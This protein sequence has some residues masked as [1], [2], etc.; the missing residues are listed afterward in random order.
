[1]ISV[2]GELAVISHKHARGFVK[3]EE[4]QFSKVKYVYLH[5]LFGKNTANIV[6]H[7]DE[8]CVIE[9]SD[10]PRMGTMQSIARIES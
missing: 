7:Q 3:V 4:G 9:R 5:D 6:V 8:C 10:L 2:A 1:M